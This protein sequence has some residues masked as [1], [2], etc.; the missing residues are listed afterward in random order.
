MSGFPE[1][2]RKPLL[3]S[4][5]R[6]ALGDHVFHDDHGYGSI[7]QIHEGEDGLLINV[8]FETD[9]E[10]RFLSLHQSLRF[11]QIRD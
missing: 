4:D 7:T 10:L 6:R 11:T 5:G 3:S 8:V 9:H 2:Y 1:A